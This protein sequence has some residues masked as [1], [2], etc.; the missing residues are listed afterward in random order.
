MKEPEPAGSEKNDQVWDKC[1]VSRLQK[2]LVPSAIG[3]RRV[4]AP[5]PE[6]LTRGRLSNS[7]GPFL[8][9][10]ARRLKA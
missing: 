6:T 7:R 1:R 3:L 9:R 5:Q 10:E 2:Q 4:I 8:T